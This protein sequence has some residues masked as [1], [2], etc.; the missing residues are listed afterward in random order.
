MEAKIRREKKK[1]YYYGGKKKKAGEIRKREEEAIASYSIQR[2]FNR[3]MERFEREFN[4]F[5]QGPPKMRRWMEGLPTMPITEERLPSVDLE[6]RGKDFRLT[7][8]L[9][10][11][12]KE[13]VDIEVADQW[14]TVHAKKTMVRR[15]K[16]EKLHSQRKGPHKPI[17]GVSNCQKRF[18]QMKLKASLNN[19]ILRGHLTKESA[20]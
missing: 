17:T 13:N 14:I 12:T 3:M 16:K 15:G 18:A 20:N 11:V 19:A 5:W 8:D 1:M 6:D 9:L 2:E 10:G 7:V 4:D